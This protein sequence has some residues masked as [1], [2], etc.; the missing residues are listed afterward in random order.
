MWRRRQDKKTNKL[1]SL[2]GPAQLADLQ[3]ALCVPTYNLT[4]CSRK[5]GWVKCYIISGV[6]VH[7]TTCKK[8]NRLPTQTTSYSTL[9]PWN[10]GI[11]GRPAGRVNIQAV[12]F[13]GDT[14]ES[15]FRVRLG[16]SRKNMLSVDVEVRTHDPKTPLSV[17]NA[18]C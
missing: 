7:L 1:S 12:P 15:I 16:E 4:A 10:G 2:R 14:G 6:L 3:G 18:F 17:D 13:T 9:P 11:A 5:G 8:V